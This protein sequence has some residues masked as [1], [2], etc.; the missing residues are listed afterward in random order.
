[1]THRENDGLVHTNRPGESG[2]AFIQGRRIIHRFLLAFYGGY[3]RNLGAYGCKHFFYIPD[4][5]LRR[6][7][8]WHVT[9]LPRNAERAI[10]KNVAIL[11]DEQRRTAQ[12]RRVVF[13]E[14]GGNKLLRNGRTFGG[15]VDNLP[16]E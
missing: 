6:R 1:M 9:L 11:C 15:A 8:P 5:E 3:F 7:R 10:N 2:Y 13:L 16:C 12:L 14:Q 4:G